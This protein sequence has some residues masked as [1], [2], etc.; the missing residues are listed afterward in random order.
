MP[1]LLLD[2]CR[3]DS[4]SGF[5][6]AAR[7]RFVDGT[8]AAELGRRTAAIYLWGY[9][10]EMTIKAAYF[11]AT[12]F[13]DGRAITIGDLRDA[14]NSRLASTIDWS[15]QGRLHHVP[16][17]AEL[18]VELRASDPK[19]VYADPKFGGEIVGMG[20]RFRRVWSETLRYHENVAY[21]HEVRRIRDAADWFLGHSSIL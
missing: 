10:A 16:A 18:L 21:E 15:G 11:A 9:A 6:E 17:W 3:L 12:G 14:V 20:R 4:I 5:R 2:R 7:T 1:K 8:A 13:E 19:L